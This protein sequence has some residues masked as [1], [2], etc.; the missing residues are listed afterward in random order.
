MPTATMVIAAAVIGL[1]MAYQ[2]GGESV[3]SLFQSIGRFFKNILSPF[4]GSVEAGKEYVQDK[5]KEMAADERKQEREEQQAERQAEKEE[6]QKAYEEK[7]EAV[8]QAAEMRQ[9][10]MKPFLPQNWENLGAAGRMEASL[11]LVQVIADSMGLSKEYMVT[12]EDTGTEDPKI[13]NNGELFV[14]DK[15]YIESESTGVSVELF[16]GIVKQLAYARQD[17]IKDGLIDAAERE[18]AMA[19][20]A[21]YNESRTVENISIPKTYFLNNRINQIDDMPA[22][23]YISADSSDTYERQAVAG[24]QPSERMPNMTYSIYFLQFK[25]LAEMDNM[26]S[27]VTKDMLNECT[28]YTYYAMRDAMNELYGCRNIESEI[29]KALAVNSQSITEKPERLNKQ[30]QYAVSVYQVQSYAE[31]HGGA[32]KD[33]RQDVLGKLQGN[34]AEMSEKQYSF[35]KGRLEYEK[36][37]VESVLSNEEFEK[38]HPKKE[39]REKDG[40]NDREKPKDHSKNEPKDKPGKTGEKEKPGSSSKDKSKDNKSKDD[41]KDKQ[42]DKP[43]DK[44]KDKPKGNSKDSKSKEKEPDKENPEENKPDAE[45]G[46]SQETEKSKDKEKDAGVGSSVDEKDIPVSADDS[47]SIP[48]VDVLDDE[49]KKMI[50]D[51]IMNGVES[52]E[53]DEEAKEDFTGILNE[54]EIHGFENEEA[55]RKYLGERANEFFAFYDGTESEYAETEYPDTGENP[56]FESFENP[57]PDEFYEAETDMFNYGENIPFEEESL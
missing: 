11:N 48:F 6:K 33:P 17:E 54:D 36:V 37:H 5:E 50:E 42:K 28:N 34:I 29:D 44:S 47:H 20:S 1:R 13:L 9:D 39:S 14:F 24:L 8:K 18:K 22:L 27:Q 38:R 23:S 35:N 41:V 10:A 12:F 2:F 56:L 43:K 49:T 40:Q 25:E 51:A 21:G 45:N 7:Q 4:S 52:E 15:A 57:V 26:T 31:S 55:Y 53:W 30:V 32:F 19:A 16:N 3:Q 46:A